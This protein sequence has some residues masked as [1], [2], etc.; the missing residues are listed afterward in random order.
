MLLSYLVTLF[1]FWLVGQLSK[2]V[3]V[4]I[5]LDFC[6]SRYENFLIP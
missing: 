1:N 4:L 2:F 3:E 5:I 6:A